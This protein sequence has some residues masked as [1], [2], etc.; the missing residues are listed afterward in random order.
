MGRLP[1]AT[2]DQLDWLEDQI[3]E[4]HASQTKERTKK[5]LSRVEQ[6]YFDKFWKVPGTNGYHE[7]MLD[8]NGHVISKAQRQVVSTKS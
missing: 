3:P 5:F 4:F 2:D 6:E 8:R 7:S 1:W